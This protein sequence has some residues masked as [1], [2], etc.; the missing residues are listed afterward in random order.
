MVSKEM[1]TLEL[2]EINGTALKSLDSKS[3]IF[4]SE[5]YTQL[6][7]TF[8]PIDAVT[9]GVMGKQ[10]VEMCTDGVEGIAC[11]SGLSAAN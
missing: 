4:D 11:A 5:R 9:Y 2:L 7:R 3:R 1:I 6:R 8:N 10:E